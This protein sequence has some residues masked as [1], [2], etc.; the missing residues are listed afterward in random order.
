[1]KL[2][3]SSSIHIVFLFISFNMAACQ[4][5]NIQDMEMDAA[6]YLERGNGY[7]EKGNYDRAISK[8]LSEWL[9]KITAQ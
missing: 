9:K 1:M 4:V 5:H 2:S 3:P 7:L 6:G 8:N